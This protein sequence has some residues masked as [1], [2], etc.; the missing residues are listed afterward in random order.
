MQTFNIKRFWQTMKWMMA[1]SR[2]EYITAV[3]SIFF[4][5]TLVF[6][7]FTFTF[8]G[9]AKSLEYVAGFCSGLLSVFVSIGGC[10]IASNMKTKQQIIMVKMLPSSNLEKF[11]S[12]FLYVTV[13]WYVGGLVAYCAADLLNMLVRLITNHAPV[14]SATAIMYDV[15][16]RHDHVVING[17]SRAEF[18]VLFYLFGVWAHSFYILGGTLLRKQQFVITTLTLIALGLA[19]VYLMGVLAGM[20]GEDM[21]MTF[22]FVYI[23]D[24]VFVALT[25]I[26]Y[27][28]SYKLYAN[29]QVIN[30]KWFN[31]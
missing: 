26:D 8:T 24:A 27:W 23:L 17:S 14:E 19:F 6:C 1:S 2:K 11:L 9:E 31:I 4:V 22:T 20:F 15:L 28:I 13:I 3:S 21:F 7:A 5:F 29:M 25:L 12:R 18:D 10:A 30:N 16:F